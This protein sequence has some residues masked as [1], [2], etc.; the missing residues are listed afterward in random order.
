[1][2]TLNAGDLL[3]VRIGGHFGLLYEDS[4]IFDQAVAADQTFLLGLE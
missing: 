4:D 2:R 3:V 1:M